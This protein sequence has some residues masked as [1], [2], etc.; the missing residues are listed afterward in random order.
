MKRSTI[1]I[2]V[3]ALTT[4]ILMAMVGIS[5]ARDAKIKEHCVGAVFGGVKE[6]ARE[7]HSIAESGEYGLQSRE[8]IAGSLKAIGNAVT[9]MNSYDAGW[10]SFGG[11]LFGLSQVLGMW[12]MDINDTHVQ[13]IP[14]DGKISDGERAFLTQLSADLDALLAPMLAE[15]GLNM[16]TGLKW[17]DFRDALEAFCETYST[18]NPAFAPFDLL[19]E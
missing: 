13:S 11:G 16:R 5:A 12:D 8:T 15:D 3:L 14:Y 6:L 9:V 2:L 19:N 17:S 18:W 4:A 7:T 1:I 10:K